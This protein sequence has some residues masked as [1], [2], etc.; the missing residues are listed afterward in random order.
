MQRRAV[1]PSI[2]F[3]A[4]AEGKIKHCRIKQEG[5]LFIIGNASFESLLELV[6]YYEKQPLYRRMRLRYPVNDQLVE[7]IGTVSNR[8]LHPEGTI[9][10]ACAITSLSHCQSFVSI[11]FSHPKFSWLIQTH[12]F[13]PVLMILPT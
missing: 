1:D 3:I 11:L 9:M 4:R 5:R 7:K 2:V 8:T 12:L 10:L 6:Q 13:P